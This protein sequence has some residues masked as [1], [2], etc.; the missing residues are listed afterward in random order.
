M[1]KKSWIKKLDD[2][3]ND[4]PASS[5]KKIMPMELGD[6]NEKTVMYGLAGALVLIFILLIILFVRTGKDTSMAGIDEVY[7]RLATLERQVGILAEREEERQK[8]FVQFSQ[9]EEDVK[10]R[11]D[12]QRE[13]LDD[14]RQKIAELEKRPAPAAAP[15]RREE[16]RPEAR[17]DTTAQDKIVHEV[18]RGE[19]LFRIGLKYDISVDEIMRLN[20]LSPN[21]S[22]HPGQKLIVG[23]KNN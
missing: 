16:P 1:E 11:L 5:Q 22:I 12:N 8:F 9:T 21:D 2:L 23:T 4:K 13:V 10:S 6:L 15:P 17:P 19:N 14:L 7:S 18:Q 20:N 3:D